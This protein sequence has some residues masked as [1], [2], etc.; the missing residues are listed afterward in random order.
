LGGFGAKAP[1]IFTPFAVVM[2]RIVWARGPKHGGPLATARRGAM[3]NI[4]K[5]A[6][7]I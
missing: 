1:P 3:L 2:R 5:S 6:L 4:G 7:R